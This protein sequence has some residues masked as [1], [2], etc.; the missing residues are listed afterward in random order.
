[1]MM[2]IAYDIAHPRR[3]QRVAKVLKDYGL[4]VQNSIFE[5]N[6]NP[7]TFRDLRRRTEEHLDFLEDGVKYF[8]LCGR[9]RGLVLNIGPAAGEEQRD[10]LIV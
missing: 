5:V 8:P 6:I 3:L 4:R 1:M 10:L 9:C 2:I 7:T